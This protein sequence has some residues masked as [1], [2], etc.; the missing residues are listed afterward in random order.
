MPTTKSTTR[1]LDCRA[2]SGKGG[3]AEAEPWDTLMIYK[4]LF[5]RHLGSTVFENIGYENIG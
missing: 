1:L 4:I 5:Y 3:I 2:S